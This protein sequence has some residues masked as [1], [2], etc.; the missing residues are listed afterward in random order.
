MTHIVELLK[1][2]F[3]LAL[4]HSLESCVNCDQSYCDICGFGEMSEYCVASY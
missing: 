1:C 3:C 4:G 2:P